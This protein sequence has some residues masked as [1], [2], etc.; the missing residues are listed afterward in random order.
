MM[1]IDYDRNFSI[2]TL[3]LYELTYTS[4][5]LIKNGYPRKPDNAEL[6]THIRE[7]VQCPKSLPSKARKV[8]VKKMKHSLP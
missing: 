1:N 8:P 7:L 3:I 4:F 5:Y 6:A 2:K